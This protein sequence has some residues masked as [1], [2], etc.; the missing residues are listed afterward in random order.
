MI[1]FSES[2]IFAQNKYNLSELGHETVL[3]IKTP[4]HWGVTGWIELGLVGGSTFL[5]SQFD[6]RIKDEAIANYNLHPTYRKNI[7]MVVGDQWGGFFVGPI[8]C[9]S[10]YATGSIANSNKTKKIGFEI[11]QAL[12]YSEAISFTS[13]SIIGRARPF[14][15]RAPD[16][17]KPFSFFNSPYN[18]FP[19]GHTDCAFALST[20][21]AKNTDS[22]ILK[23]VA[24]IPAA[25]TVVSR[26]YTN[27]HWASD[28][29]IGSALGYFVGNWVV[30][31]HENKDSRVQVT[32]LYPLGLKVSLD[33][34]N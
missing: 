5:I 8:L 14:T 33:Q 27:Q 25:L 23:C 1:L 31:V 24:Y 12:L 3:F 2:T 34:K 19:A 21:L 6:Q 13:K 26:V 32:S 28:V 22:Y 7:L 30:N 4:A 29:F 15:G 9:V 10:L 17:F 16:Y 20:V 18:S 11:G